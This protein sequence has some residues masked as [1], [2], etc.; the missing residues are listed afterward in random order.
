MKTLLRVLSILSLVGGI[1]GFISVTI[2]GMTGAFA[3]GV[4]WFTAV[5]YLLSGLISFAV[6][7]G[8]AEIIGRLEAIEAKR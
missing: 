8:M 4:S 6:L 1:L 3:P 5:T 2:P 7:G